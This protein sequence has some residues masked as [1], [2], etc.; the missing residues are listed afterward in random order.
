MPLSANGTY[1]VAPVPLGQA[2]PVQVVTYQPPPGYALV[3]M[4]EVSCNVLSL[5]NQL[6]NLAIKFTHCHQCQRRFSKDNWK[7][8]QYLW[9]FSLSSF[10]L[11]GTSPP[12]LH[13]MR[14]QL[15]ENKDL[16]EDE[17]ATLWKIRSLKTISVD[18]LLHHTCLLISLRSLHI[19]KIDS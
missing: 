9:L 5:N 6:L 13:H 12:P 4:S 11:P 19:Y 16:P 3:P 17:G 7:S 2:A 1:Y 15:L 10:K 8:N 18:I 14:R